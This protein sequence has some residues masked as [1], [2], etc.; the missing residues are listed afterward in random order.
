MPQ[1]VLYKLNVRYI[2][3]KWFDNK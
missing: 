2:I 1:Y 3:C